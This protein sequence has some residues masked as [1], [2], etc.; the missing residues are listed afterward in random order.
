M[1]TAT[2]AKPVWVPNAGPQT[3][4]LACPVYEVLYGGAAGGGKSDALLIDALGQVDKPRYRALILRR[5][6]PELQ[7]LID[8]SREYYPAAFPGARFNKTD[9][10][11]TFPSGARIEFGY[12]ANDDDVY[13]YQGQEYSYLGWDEVTHFS[14]FAYKYLMSRCRS[15]DPAITCRIRATANPGGK[16]HA[17]V[18]ARFI[19]PAPGLSTMMDEETGQERVFIPSKLK[20][21]PHLAKT[22]YG[23]RLMALPEADRKALL[24]GD[25]NAYEGEVFN[26]EQGIHIW[27]WA[28]FKERTGHDKIPQ[29]W[30]RFR[31][32]D[33]GYAKPFA[34]YWYAVDYEGRAYVYREFY[35]IAK[36]GKHQII[37]NEGARLEP[38]KV[39]EKVAS[40]EKEARETIATGWTGPDIGQNVRADHGGGK[41]I[42]DH[43]RAHGVFWQYWT[44]SAGS[45]LAG[46]MALHQ[47]LA[48]ERGEDG[49]IR[50]WPG[51]IFI[52]E[53]CPHAIRTIPA[54]EYDEHQPEQVNTDG[55]DHAYD[56]I[57]GFCKMKPWKPVKKTEKRDGWRERK[58]S[59]GS[60]WVAG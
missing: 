60:S 43:F 23:R 33:W 45:R 44:A 34:I 27:T 55:E 57:S 15:T 25:W 41:K 46:K 21:N 48:Y 14:E 13:R 12:I 50:E 24:D 20:N 38:E 40:I 5:S 56:S 53:A 2:K 35:G 54:L 26:L 19:D 36:D 7:E 30:T 11:W 39:A 37:P 58:Q 59:P 31:S 42:E 52:E 8:R 18:K 29:E 51:L 1:V 17:W 32:M 49:N 10:R 28:Q 4:F 16:G 47:R 3:A 9:K 22:D 6:Y